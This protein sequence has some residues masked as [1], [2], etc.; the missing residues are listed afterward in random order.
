MQTENLE[1]Q[2]E[3]IE[4]LFING[5][6]KQL[7]LE[8]CPT[9]KGKMSFYISKFERFESSPKGRRIKCGMTIYCVGKCRIM[10]SHG[11]GYCPAWAEEIEDWEKFNSD[12][13]I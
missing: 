10:L 1:K 11:D 13:Y 7:K 12:L 5:D 8:R 6:I 2:I 9:C 4:I 3:Y